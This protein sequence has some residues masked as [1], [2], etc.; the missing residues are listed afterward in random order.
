MFF[1]MT[2]FFILPR[3]PPNRKNKKKKK[4]KKKQ[5]FMVKIL[6][7]PNMCT[8]ML[9]LVRAYIHWN[10][11][12]GVSYMSS[13][14]HASVPIYASTYGVDGEERRG[15]ERRGGYFVLVLGNEEVFW[16]LGFGVSGIHASGS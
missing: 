15:E 11:D 10:S 16:V 8:C 13:G 12:L 6:I 2:R 1:L 9:V 4:E 7:V 5:M 14:L 3:P